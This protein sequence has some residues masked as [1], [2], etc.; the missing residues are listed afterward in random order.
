MANQ[1]SVNVLVV[2]VVDAERVSDLRQALIKDRFYFTLVDSRGGLIGEAEECMLVGIPE[3]RLPE[4]LTL[5]EAHCHTRRVYVPARFDLGMMQG[6]PM[7]VEAEVGGASVYILEID[8]FV[9]I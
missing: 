8:Q 5:V 6:Q 9:Q 2:I 7:M 1:E 4:L 3:A